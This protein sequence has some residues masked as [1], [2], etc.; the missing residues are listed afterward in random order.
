M[1][2]PKP[3]W[4]WFFVLWTLFGVLGAWVAWA[5]G[6]P[7]A[8]PALACCAL[9]LAAGVVLAVVVRQRAMLRLL[10]KGARPESGDR[11]EEAWKEGLS[12]DVRELFRRGD[13]RGE[14]RSAR[15]VWT[16][17][18]DPELPRALLE[19][20]GAVDATESVGH[21]LTGEFQALGSLLRY[22][23]CDFLVLKG[24][25]EPRDWDVSSPLGFLLDRLGR[26]GRS[27]AVDAALVVG[28]PGPDGFPPSVRSALGSLAEASGMEFPVHLCL[29]PARGA[30]DGFF[31]A[32]G[33][34]PGFQLPRCR[35]EDLP[36]VLDEGF[37]RMEAD[38][39]GKEA[40]LLAAAWERGIPPE[41]VI[42]FAD[43][44][45]R[46]REEIRE[47][48]LSC[49]ARFVRFP[50][51][52]L[53]GVHLLP[54]PPRA[55]RSPSDP[56]IGVDFGC[57]PAPASA[58]VAG[59]G[60]A[61]RRFLDLLR[62]EP[63]LARPGA[64]MRTR[65]HVLAAVA[66]A[67][68]CV[69]SALLGWAA[70]RG[71][72]EGAAMER[73]W[74]ARIARDSSTAW[75]DPA[76][77]RRGLPALDDALHLVHEAGNRP[78]WFPPGF[79]RGRRNLSSA[80]RVLDSME[81]RLVRESGA[82]LESRLRASTAAGDPRDSRDLYNSLK[83]YLLSTRAGWREGGGKEGEKGL[84]EAL[85]RSWADYLGF[86]DLPPY[87][88]GVL[89]R[90]AA[91]IAA[92]AADGDS[93]WLSIQDAGL[94]AA[95]RRRLLSAGSQSGAFARL[96]ASAD[97]LPGL[98]WD[99]LGFPQRE[100]S[101]GHLE[102]PP[103]F[104]KRGW[105][106][107][108]KPAFEALEKGE[109]DWVVGAERPQAP[110]G[111]AVVQELER[112]YVEE[113]TRAWLAALD[114][115]PCRL[116][117][118]A[119]RAGALLGVLA[120]P[121]SPGNR[122]ILAFLHRI[123]EE[124]DLADTAASAPPVPIPKSALKSVL[125]VRAAQQALS[126]PART[127]SV[128]VR[129]AR[130]LSSVR[131]LAAEAGK[132]GLDA[133]LKD[134]AQAG[135]ALGQGAGGDGA[136]PFL[137][138]IV[139]QDARN[140]VVHGWGEAVAR[141]D[142][143]PADIRPWFQALSLGLLR[144]AGELAL[145][146]ARDRARELY[147]EKVLRPWQNLS[148][149]CFPFDPYADRDASIAEIDA[150]LN[151][152]TGT[153]AAFL[154]D[155]DGLVVFR[156]G[157]LRAS[158]F[159]GIALALDPAASEPMRRLARISEFAYGKGSPAWKGANA[160]VQVRADSRAKVV[161]RVGGQS[162]EVPPGA[163]RRLPLRWPLPGQGGASLRVSTVNRSFEESREGEWA[164]LRLMDAKAPGTGEATWSFSDRSYVVD[165][166]MSVRVEPLDGPFRDRDF[167][168]V[169]LPPD[170]FR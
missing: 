43:G 120:G 32:S 14:P 48:A 129:V 66:L 68:A 12:S 1:R 21:G 74:R 50:R 20:S 42:L 11:F 24:V 81:R 34:A 123:Q 13:G 15:V 103:A 170:L 122:G 128:E 144:Q 116:P 91:G 168:R 39:D 26:C 112:R 108:V 119:Q 27:R 143:L 77:M 96:V 151:P 113:Y 134:L 106:R 93:S 80:S 133:F 154:K 160:T 124:T 159:N 132:G 22:G 56:D 37:A 61:S 72:V 166:P 6:V 7:I 49:T 164:L 65:A 117:S 31:G 47:A 29:C 85:Q 28:N 86:A 55:R 9:W 67:A 148:N 64:G 169:V 90:A 157:D 137:R 41:S 104:T 45:R 69:L 25:P 101:C 111:D 121:G 76:S 36:G 63:D 165:V 35:Q 100:M 150:V 46:G 141:R 84:A 83:A 130:N 102:I 147:R 153:L 105:T 75:C 3:S 23:N 125:A 52:F 139:A 58:P 53:R 4:L 136:L 5:V 33:E 44:V 110:G 115:N 70:V 87:E 161:L 167:F 156:D 97:T 30:A 88:R 78:W 163:E 18:V 51:P 19:S 54:P 17:S 145:P 146:A 126:G 127:E 162:V 155:L 57:V 40:G 149:G 38:L 114:T 152:A 107:A 59:G 94:V 95:A 138:G 99:S 82:A 158:S 89:Y 79:F 135:A 131:G 60:E 8:W 62:E 109:V 92:R 142:L 2:F 98:D 118:D 140:P 73:D 16:I 10:A 71:W